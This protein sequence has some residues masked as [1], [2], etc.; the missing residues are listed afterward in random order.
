MVDWLLYRMRARPDHAAMLV[1]DLQRFEPVESD[2]DDVA[3]IELVKVPYDGPIVAVFREAGELGIR[4]DNGA[5]P[6]REESWWQRRGFE[7][8]EG[9][10][11]I[12][13]ETYEERAE[14]GPPV[15]FPVAP[16]ELA[17]LVVEALTEYFGLAPTD[18][19]IATENG[20]PDDWPGSESDWPHALP[21]ISEVRRA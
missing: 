8:A 9:E 15:R 7:P 3:E 17:R 2:E 16:D 6:A 5:K 18:D 1:H 13:P 20:N 19:V 10:P 11:Y 14:T 12:D 4:L 21:S